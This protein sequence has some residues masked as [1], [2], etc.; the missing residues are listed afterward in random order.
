VLRFLFLPIGFCVLASSHFIRVAMSND[1]QA[2]RDLI[3][4]WMAA[5]KAGD[6]ATV[7]GMMTD[8]VVFMVPGQEPFGKEAFAARSGQM[9]DLRID[10]TSEIQEIK[11]LGDWAWMRNRLSVTIT[12]PGGQPVTR[13]GY[14]LT[15]LHKQADGAWAIARDANLLTP[16]E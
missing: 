9:K 8:D 10:G 1:E 16:Q 6:T 11:V 7:L 15:V 12:P 4:R 2:I 13:S 3:D 14:T 5:S